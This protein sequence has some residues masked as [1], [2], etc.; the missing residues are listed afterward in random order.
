MNISALHAKAARLQREL[1]DIRDLLA[2]ENHDSEAA[3]ADLSRTRAYAFSAATSP[4]EEVAAGC[5]D[6]LSRYGFC[7]ID[8]VI[9]TSEVDAIRD[10]IVAAQS[11]IAR[12]IEDIK[13]LVERGGLDPRELLDND[14]VELRPVRRVGYPPKPPNDI[15]W[16]PQYAQHLAHPVVTA[17]ARRVLDDHLRIAQLHPRI[18]AADQPD[19]TPGGFG[20]PKYRGRADSREWHTDWPHDLS[21][22]GRG[23]PDQNV[24]CIRQPFP[25]VTM[26][27]VM[28]WYLT[29]VDED[30]GGTWV[31]PG[32][33][34][35]KRNPRGPADDMTVTAPIPG[36]MQVTAPA[37]SVYI[38]DSRSWHASAMH[39]PSG[40]ARVAVVNR[41]CPWWL[42]VDD[43]APG[44]RYNIVCRPLS[45]AEYLDL[46]A[47]LQPLL[48]HLCPDERDALQQPVLDRADAAGLRTQSGFRQ[49]EEK[50][51]DLAAANA[52]I[53]VP[54]GPVGIKTGAE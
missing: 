22:Y 24:G 46:P 21:A 25:D 48:R 30:S 14:K 19:G 13:D 36:D 53:R 16:M 37:G 50:P 20:S 32:S 7:V 17:V 41:W 5:A 54:L 34:K 11:T 29:D 28:I 38:Q 9:P 12:N 40:R 23:D 27:L 49:L 35:D 45:H 44:G 51:D 8:H 33:H 10:E 26:C 52:H 43:Y 1:Q 4:V 18:I 39:N 3:T 42:S 47:D 31:V 6:S 15:V 2:R